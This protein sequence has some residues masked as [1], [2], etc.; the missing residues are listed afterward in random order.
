MYTKE[1]IKQAEENVMKRG[2]AKIVSHH[3]GFIIMAQSERDYK[4]KANNINSGNTFGF[5]TV[6]VALNIKRGL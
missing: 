3:N 6:D 4:S 2:L 5:C 1:Q